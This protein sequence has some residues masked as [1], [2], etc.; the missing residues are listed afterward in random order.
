MKIWIFLLL[1]GF[2]AT[3]AAATL[4]FRS[5]EILAAELS[6]RAP[7][8]ANLDKYDYEFGFRKRTYALL[9]VKL[10]PGR[11][12][13]TDDYSL[14]VF[15]KHYPCVAIRVG[16]GS[17]DTKKWEIDAPSPSQLYGLLFIVDGTVAGIDSIEKLTLKCNAP[18]KYRRTVVPFSTIGDRAFRAAAGIPAAGMLPDGKN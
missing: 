12:I 1:A 15:G 17:F 5:G 6:S 13:A 14:E 11:T 4:P 16:D 18:G 8:I 9:T 3:L 2:S 7:E 10:A